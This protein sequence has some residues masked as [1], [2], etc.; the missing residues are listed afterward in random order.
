M[1]KNRMD[2][3]SAVADRF[4]R[5][6]LSSDDTAAETAEAIVEFLRARQ[7]AKVPL[8]TGTDMLRMMYS[9]LGAQ[10]EARDHFITAHA[11]TPD[12]IDSIGLTRMWGDVSPCPPDEEAGFSTTGQVRPLRAA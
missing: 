1:L 7:R 6:E 5:A 9:A 10:L 2:A 4:R 3:A 8:A 11:M 12:V